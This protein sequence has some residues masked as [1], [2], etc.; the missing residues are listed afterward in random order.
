MGEDDGGLTVGFE[1][2]VHLLEGLR[3]HVFV[4][5][6]GFLVIAAVPY[7]VL[8]RLLGFRREWGTELRRVEMPSGAPQPDIKKVRQVGIGDGIVIGWVGNYSV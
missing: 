1:D 4:K 2:A 7:R 6:F 8:H 5:R 3:H